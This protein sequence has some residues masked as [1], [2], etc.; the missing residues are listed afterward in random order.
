MRKRLLSG[1]AKQIS[2]HPWRV[3]LIL[4]LVSLVFAALA[5]QLTFTT[6]VTNLMPQ[7]DPMIVEFNKVMEEYAGA[8]SMLVVVEGRPDKLVEFADRVTPKIE[9]QTEYVKKVDY[10]LPREF[11]E[12]HALM[13]MKSKDLEN[14]RT[15]FENPNLVEF[16]RNL[17]DSFEK[18]YT[19]S[20]GGSIEGQEQERGVIKFMDG[21]QS[22]VDITDR[23]LSGDASAD[24]GTRA[25]DAVLYGDLY[26][27]SWDREMLIMQII[28]TFS[29]LDIEKD[30]AATNLIEGL[31]KDEAK[32]VGVQA[33]LTGSIPLSRDEMESI[34]NDSFLITG[35]AL[36]GI[37][38]LFIVAFRMAVSP[39]LAII[40]LMIGV[41][42]AMGLA[43][44]LV[45]QLNLMTSMMAVVL[46][47]LGI[48]FSIHIIAVYTEA[49][50]R[51]ESIADA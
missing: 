46:V 44:V 14:N 7:D 18:E 25:A 50:Q 48:D 29:F 2:T 45:Q 35:L 10:K 6:S 41:L 1:L 31:V 49:R 5:E 33:G 22:F 12:N 21:I 11:L 16:V 13:L 23:V 38:V 8:A 19:G 30:V 27:R 42:W 28:P 39:V 26:Y 20:G 9:A 36:I 34:E 37:L 51:G 15:L 4:L 43:W 32:E 47:G 24:A 40:T 17:N 3:G